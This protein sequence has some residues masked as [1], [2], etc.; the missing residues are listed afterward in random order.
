[1]FEVAFN[2]FT[3]LCHPT[4]LPELY[5]EYREKAALNEKFELQDW[6]GGAWCFIGV[7]KDSGNG[8]PFLTVAQNY[9]PAGCGFN[10]GV[11]LVPETSVLFIGAGERLLAYD[12]K[13]PKRLWID[14]ANTG[15]WHWKRH[16]SIVLMSAEL[17]LA[18]WT[19]DGVKL[20]STFVEPPWTYLVRGESLTLDVMGRKSGFSLRHGP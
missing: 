3:I 20:W 12:L 11:L 9:W 19:I 6:T 17:E 14:S 16:G 5:S 13:K 2:E 10:P 7:R 1:M 15:F 4:A 18:A 8:W